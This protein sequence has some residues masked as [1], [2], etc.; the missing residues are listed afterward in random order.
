MP[1]QFDRYHDPRLSPTHPE[2]G[3][4]TP[5][6][7]GLT[8]VPRTVLLDYLRTALWTG[9][10]DE[11]EPL[12]RDFTPSDFSDDAVRAA[13]RAVSTFLTEVER[14]DLDDTD[15]WDDAG[16]WDAVGHDL[17]LTRN[18]HGAGFWDGDWGTIGDALTTIAGR[19]G[20]VDVYQGD[21]GQLH[22]AG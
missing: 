20:E 11:G 3:A 12:D 8:E 14:L 5:H 15:A 1:L 4:P 6:L 13:Q 22:F 18:G 21:D 19:L 10:G 16:G 17:W 2:H 9:T 7:D